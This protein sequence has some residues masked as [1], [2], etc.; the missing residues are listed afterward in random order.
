MERL[1]IRGTR[2]LDGRGSEPVDDAVLVAEGERI[3]Y[4]GPA[5]GAPAPGADA[6]VIDAAGRSLAPGLIDCHVHLCFD[7]V[8]DFAREAAEMNE[9]SAALK[10]ARNARLAL[11]A[12]ITTLRDL[13]GHK[14]AMIDVARAQAAG[15]I[16]GPRILA[17]GA[18]LTI[19]G[20][21]GHFL[22]WEA[23][24]AD[25]LVKAVRTLVKAGAD[26]IKIIATGGVLTPGIGAQRSQYSHEQLAAAIAEAHEAGKRVAT[27]AIGAAGILKALRAGVDSV[28]HGC[29]L[30]EEAIKLLVENQAWLVGT[31]VAPERIM[32]GGEGVPEYAVRKSEEVSVAH[33]DSFRRAVE[34]GVRIASGTDAGTPFNPHGGLWRELRLMHEAGMPPEQLLVAATS[35]AAALLDLPDV[36]A[37]EP[38]KVA[39][40]VLLD[41]DPLEDVGAY[42]RVAL[43]AQ[44]GRVVVDRRAS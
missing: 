16:E 40:L 4:A 11:E 42:E 7:G 26:W 21:H 37:L 33:R 43:V 20:G 12:G 6:T 38:G 5:A 22:G 36:G 29:Y 24:S 27:H 30:T 10:A 17:A 25:E 39:D 34:A 14:L 2:L 18:A 19:T 44:A 3:S 8:A 32:H 13:G 41:G 35:E 9:A 31:L 23:D 1:V 28:E 15:I